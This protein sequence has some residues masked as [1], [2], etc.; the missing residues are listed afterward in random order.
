MR[1]LRLGF[2]L[3]SFWIAFILLS[4]IILT[5]KIDFY[6]LFPPLDYTLKRMATVSVLFI[7][8]SQNQEQI[9][10]TSE[11]MNEWMSEWVNEWKKSKHTISG[12]QVH[13]ELGFLPNPPLFIWVMLSR[14][15]HFLEI[16]FSCL[17]NKGAGLVNLWIYK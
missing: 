5:F 4:T 9:I 11:W 12:T 14:S 6:S 3:F 16:Y 17:Q 1:Q 13:K 2:I 8:V 7:T 15:F 10:L